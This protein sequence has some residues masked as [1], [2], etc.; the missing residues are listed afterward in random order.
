ML[1]WLPTP[2]THSQVTE[3]YLNDFLWYSFLLVLGAIPLLCAVSFPF[4]WF[5]NYCHSRDRW[6]NKQKQAYK[7][8]IHICTD[9]DS[10][11]VNYVQKCAGS[12]VSLLYAA[13]INPGPKAPWRRKGLF[14]LAGHSSTEGHQGRNLGRWKG[15]RVGGEN[16]QKDTIQE[17]LRGS[18]GTSY[19]IWRWF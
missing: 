7:L 19:N 2:Q 11:N 5:G 1:S 18:M 16:E 9:S 17:H 15:D 8:M 4:K 13:M 6:K 12:Y 10:W 14:H 3:A